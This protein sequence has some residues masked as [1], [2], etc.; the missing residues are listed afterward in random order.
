[1]TYDLTKS[2]DELRVE[3]ASALDKLKKMRAELAQLEADVVP[4]RDKL[5]AIDNT[6]AHI[7]NAVMDGKQSM[8]RSL[9]VSEEVIAAAEAE[10]KAIKVAKEKLVATRAAVAAESE[11]V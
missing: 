10:V 11:S 6:K 1:M 5:V 8:L 2:T 9:G 7:L 3:Y 4:L